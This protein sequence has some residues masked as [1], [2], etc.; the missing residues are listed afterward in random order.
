VG[1]VWEAFGPKDGDSWLRQVVTAP[2]MYA[3]VGLAAWVQVHGWDSSGGRLATW[4]AARSGT[5]QA[6]VSVGAVLAAATATSV[7]S[8][9][10]PA[11]LR[12][13]EGY[14]PRP[15]EWLRERLIRRHSERAEKWN[16]ELKALQD[17]EA[18]RELTPAERRKFVRLDLTLR[19]IPTRS[20]AR[21]PTRIGNIL[22]AAECWPRD[23]YGLDAVI[24]WPRLWLVLRGSTRDEIGDARAGLD[25]AIC[26]LV[27]GV[28]LALW[29]LVALW[30]VGVAI[31]VAAFFYRRIVTAAEDYGDLV[32]AAFDLERAE[33]YRQLRAPL[34][35]TSDL[36]P[37]EGAAL[38]QY[39]WRGI[40]SIRFE[41]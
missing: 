21:M 37:A 26:G 15:L 22:R 39:L 33:L 29:G 6:L 41:K 23:K 7:V 20:E 18:N 3:F 17:E 2:A 28:L 12:G 34:P 36:E 11:V 31:I 25:Q 24:V 27:W 16:D 10:A 9:M 30:A 38:T 19:R 1:K 40:G 13:L 35:P 4:F 32:E 5:E 14:W 8:G